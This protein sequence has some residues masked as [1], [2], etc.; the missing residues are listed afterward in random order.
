MGAMMPTEL[1][2]AMTVV[3]EKLNLILEILSNMQNG[4]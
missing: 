1:D 4:D 2:E 3:N